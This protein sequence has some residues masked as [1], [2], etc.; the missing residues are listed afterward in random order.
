MPII[1]IPVTEVTSDSELFLLRKEI[2]DALEKE[3]ISRKAVTVEFLSC[4]C[5]ERLV[6]NYDSRSKH[7][8]EPGRPDHDAKTVGKIVETS[9][10]MPVECIVHYCDAGHTG[11]YLTEH[12]TVSPSICEMHGSIEHMQAVS[13]LCPRCGKI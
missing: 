13:G 9:L 3:G 10:K 1:T 2:R 4:R 7:L 11:L 6:I 8:L 5:P 12:V